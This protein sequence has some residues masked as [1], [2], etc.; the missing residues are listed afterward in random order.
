MAVRS[1]DPDCYHAQNNNPEENELHAQIDQ[2]AKEHGFTYRGATFFESCGPSASVNC[3]DAKGLLPDI[4]LPGGFHPQAESI[5][6]SY[7]NDPRNFPAF[8]KIVPGVD[9]TVTPANRIAELYPMMVKAVF[10]KTVLYRSSKYTWDEL[11]VNLALGNTVQL[12]FITPGHFFAAVD[13]ADVNIVYNDSWDGR[14]GVPGFR[15]ILTEAEYNIN[16]KPY[17]ILY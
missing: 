14:G 15:R 17:A 12:C 4:A 8:A 7:F 13:L 5:A 16:V 9:F 10:G 2:L 11:R 1:K 3:L 6:M